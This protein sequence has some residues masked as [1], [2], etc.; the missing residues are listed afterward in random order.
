M[1]DVTSLP[2]TGDL[3]NPGNWRPISNT[4]ISS[5]ILEKL[6]QRQ[7][8]NYIFTN[9]IIPEYQYGFVPKHSTHEAVFKV[10]KNKYSAIN[11]NI[12]I[13]IVFL[14]IAKVFNCVNHEIL[15]IVLFNLG[16][17]ERARQWFWSYNKR[18][19]RVKIDNVFFVYSSSST[20]CGSR[21]GVR[22]NHFHTVF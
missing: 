8:R 5:K 3:S 4:N 6:V 22:S 16:F 10:V 1:A 15:D 2:K 7:M 20:R 9:E 13:G 19:Q 14:D 17:S 11:N 12:Y 18:S 21:Y